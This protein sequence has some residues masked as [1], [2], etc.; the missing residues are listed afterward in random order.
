[1]NGRNKYRF[2]SPQDFVRDSYLLSIS[3]LTQ[4]TILKKSS[5]GASRDYCNP[6]TVT[7]ISESRKTNNSL[8]KS[9]QLWLHILAHSPLSLGRFCDTSMYKQFKIE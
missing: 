1:M 6:V 4:Y 7:R 5:V 3:V 8:Q 2:F 9:L